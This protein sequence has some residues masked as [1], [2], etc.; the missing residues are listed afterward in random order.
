MFPG[1]V[2]NDIFSTA[3]TREISTFE[4]QLVLNRNLNAISSVVAG[5]RHVRSESNA[6]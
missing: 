2:V 3:E 4:L 1:G 5:M 6:P